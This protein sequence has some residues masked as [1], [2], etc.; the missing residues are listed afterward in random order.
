MAYDADHAGVLRGP[1]AELPLYKNVQVPS[2]ILMQDFRNPL[3]LPYSLGYRWGITTNSQ[4]LLVSA[5]AIRQYAAWRHMH[6]KLGRLV[7]R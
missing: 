5:V 3:Q 4:P 6:A 2:G 7:N 1:A